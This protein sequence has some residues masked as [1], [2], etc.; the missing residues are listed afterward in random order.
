MWIPSN[1]AT[2][3]ILEVGGSDRLFGRSDTQMNRASSWLLA[4]RAAIK[5]RAR[6]R[7]C[8]RSVP[9]RVEAFHWESNWEIAG[10]R[11]EGSRI[12]GGSESIPIGRDRFSAGRLFVP[13]Q[14]SATSTTRRRPCGS[15]NA[16]A[17][18]GNQYFAHRLQAPLLHTT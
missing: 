12:T 4:V 11:G 16:A 7:V 1:Q 14:I 5:V 15:I 10:S 2:E 9:A 3:Q 8:V 17:F 18:A 13:N 6:R